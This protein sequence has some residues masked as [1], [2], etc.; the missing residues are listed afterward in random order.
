MASK[1]RNLFR[2]TRFILLKLPYAMGLLAKLR[3]PAKRVLIIKTDAIGDYILFRNF[4][5]ILHASSKFKNHRVT[6]LGNELWKDLALKYD[7]AFVDDFI[8]TTVEDLYFS[9]LKTLKLGWRIF[10]SNYA[11]VLQPSSTRLLM[12]DGLAALTAAKEVIGFESDYEGILPKYKLK[13]DQ[14]Y[15]LRLA[16]PPFIDFEFERSKY[17]F[18]TVLSEKL[19]INGPSIPYEK[20]AGD[21]LVIFPGAGKLTRTWDPQK[22]IGLIKL[23]RQHSAKAI[24]LAGSCAETGTAA[25]IT[26]NLPSG[27]VI[28]L[29]GKTALP[30]LVRLIG[31]AAS[32]IA[33]ETSALHIAAATQ[34][35]SVCVLGGG[36]FGRFA[37][38]PQHI[39]N[40]PLC[41]YQEMDCYRCN[42]NCRYNTDPGEAFPCISAVALSEVWD[43]VHQLL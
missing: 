17:F 35:R 30:E 19:S 32:V 23:I 28:N 22:F 41:V 11:V 29:V 42:W 3:I 4:L 34:T 21:Y 2:I 5:E 40:R 1:N 20:A 39:E 43:A 9:P 6:L 25:Y 14:F 13:T 24:Y 8:F 15:S 12:T 18:E 16:L 38:Y 31:N 33:N 7:S 10:R 37:P 36:H 26:E 27:N